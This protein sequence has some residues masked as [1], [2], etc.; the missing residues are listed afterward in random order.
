MPL[1]K[2]DDDDDTE[3][4]FDGT[5]LDLADKSRQLFVVVSGKYRV[6]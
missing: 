6:Y 2:D 4:S 5:R 1:A 3:A